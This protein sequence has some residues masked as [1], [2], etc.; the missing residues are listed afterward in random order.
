MLDP[1]TLVVELALVTSLTAGAYFYGRY[2]EHKVDEASNAVAVSKANSEK[3]AVAKDL[4]VIKTA[5]DINAK[6]M[7]DKIEQQQS[8]MNELQTSLAAESHRYAVL[9]GRLRILKSAANPMP[10]N[11]SAAGLGKGDNTAPV[12]AGSEPEYVDTRGNIS[13][14]D[15]TRVVIHDTKTSEQ[16]QACIEQYE[17]VMNARHSK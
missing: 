3:D 15:A 4:A 6:I 1:R 17:K 16:L 10:G 14:L 2:E 9:D 11:P 5:A 12:Q 8:K 13:G 7:Q